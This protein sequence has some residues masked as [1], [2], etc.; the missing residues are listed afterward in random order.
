MD[1]M[2][3][4]VCKDEME[5]SAA[6]K[7]DHRNRFILRAF[8]LIVPE[9]TVRERTLTTRFVSIMLRLVMVGKGD[10]CQ[11]NNNR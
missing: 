6:N 5:G 7:D 11:V 1:E 4:T 8:K 9:S 10:P 3:D 2:R